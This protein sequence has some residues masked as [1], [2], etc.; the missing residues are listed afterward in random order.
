MCI[1]GKIYC[2][3]GY[4]LRGLFALWGGGVEDNTLPFIFNISFI[5]KSFLF[6]IF[7]RGRLRV[8]CHK[9]VI[10]LSRTYEKLHCKVE[11]ISF[12]WL[13]RSFSPDRQTDI[14]LLLY[15]NSNLNYNFDLLIFKQH[16]YFFQHITTNRIET[17]T[18]ERNTGEF[19]QTQNM[20]QHNALPLP[21]PHLTVLLKGK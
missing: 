13:A 8:P 17:A 9:I 10:Y 4:S 3:S 16:L 15:Q 1:T 21:T 14:L 18:R 6:E 12:L 11:P 7:S 2:T 20:N 5:R 19:I